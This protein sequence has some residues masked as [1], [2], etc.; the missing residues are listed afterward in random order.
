MDERFS[1]FSRLSISRF[2]PDEA[3]AIQAAAQVPVEGLGLTRD[4]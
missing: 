2:A 1:P 4:D 3:A